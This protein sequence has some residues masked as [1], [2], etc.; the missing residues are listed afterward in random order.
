[1]GGT[2]LGLPSTRSSLKLINSSRFSIA[3]SLERALMGKN[4]GQDPYEKTDYVTQ[5]LRIFS[6]MTSLL[7]F[8][9]FLTTD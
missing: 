5:A 8:G 1:M 4:L 9:G 3:V 6:A 7:S 2:S